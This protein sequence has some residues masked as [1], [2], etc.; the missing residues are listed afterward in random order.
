MYSVNCKS[1]CTFRYGY[2]WHKKCIRDFPGGPVV[3]TSPSSVG[4]VGSTPGW[5]AKIPHA[6]QPKTQIIE[7]KQYC[8]KFNKDFKNGPQKKKKN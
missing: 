1:I 2:L 3:G 5:G 4:G 8:D 7:Q 6:L